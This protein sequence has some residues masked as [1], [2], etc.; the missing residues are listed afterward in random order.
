M[1]ELLH[2]TTLVVVPQVLLLPRTLTDCK[3]ET[4]QTNATVGS[5]QTHSAVKTERTNYIADTETE[6]A[7]KS[8]E[9]VALVIDRLIAAHSATTATATASTGG[10]GTTRCSDCKGSK[11]DGGEELE[12]HV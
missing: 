11:S 10:W 8:A 9:E 7:S 3:R 2:W 1:P 6:E 4:E 5:Y 12:L